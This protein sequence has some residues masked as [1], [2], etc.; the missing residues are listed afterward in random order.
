MVHGPG[1]PARVSPG[2][3]PRPGPPGAPSA[4]GAVGSAGRGIRGRSRVG[5]VWGPMRQ[6]GRADRRQRERIGGTN[7]MTGK[8]SSV[9][10]GAQRCG[11]R[12]GARRRT[13]RSGPADGRGAA[14]AGSGDVTRG[15]RPAAGCDGRRP[16]PPSSRRTISGGE[17][18]RR[19]ITAGDGTPATAG[20]PPPRCCAPTPASAPSPTGGHTG[21]DPFRGRLHRP[22]SP[23][24]HGLRPAVPDGLSAPARRQR[25]RADALPRPPAAP[26][27]RADPPGDRVSGQP[28]SGRATVRS[29]ST[30]CPA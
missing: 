3:R 27:C 28:C 11:D 9:R 6:H 26:R 30:S 4:R 8:D 1:G 12:R 24:T 17:L 13:R 10:T 29:T 7:F 19:R 18:S 14:G 20:R 5:P 22:L 15:V 25:R 16:C 23:L 2:P 21:V